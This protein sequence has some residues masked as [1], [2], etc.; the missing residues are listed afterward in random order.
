MIANRIS[1]W[2]LTAWAVT[3]I[4]AAQLPVRESALLAE[5]LWLLQTGSRGEPVWFEQGPD[6]LVMVRC[7]HAPA[8][9]SAVQVDDGGVTIDGVR[10][11]STQAHGSPFIFLSGRSAALV[12]AWVVPASGPQAG[13]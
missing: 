2:F 8:C 6:G 12:P 9:R 10:F 3:G 4:A 7:R 1:G 5:R 13:P 11:T